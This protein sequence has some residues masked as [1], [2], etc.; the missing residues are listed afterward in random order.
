MDALT[1]RCGGVVGR[2][3][4]STG[5]AGKANKAHGKAQAHTP[6]AEKAADARRGVALD[7]Y[8]SGQTPREIAGK[9]GVD[10]STVWRWMQSVEWATEVSKAR[11]ERR[12]AAVETVDAAALKAVRWMVAAL[13]APETDSEEDDGEGGTRIRRGMDPRVKLAVGKELLDRAGWVPPKVEG[14]TGAESLGSALVGALERLS[15]VGKG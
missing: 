13:D 2:P 15:K 4:A 8:L 12:A 7:L 11:S 10:H 5:G 1:T 14:Q 9:V 3:K 6:V